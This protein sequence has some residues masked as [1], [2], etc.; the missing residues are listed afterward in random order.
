MNINITPLICISGGE[1]FISA[2]SLHIC[3]W[4]NEAAEC[5]LLCFPQRLFC[6]RS[7][8]VQTP[9]GGGLLHSPGASWQADSEIP[10]FLPPTRNHSLSS[11]L[12]TKV[13]S[14]SP[15]PSSRTNKE[16]RKRKGSMAIRLQINKPGKA[17]RAREEENRFQAGFRRPNS[18]NQTKTAAAYQQFQQHHSVRN[19]LGVQGRNA[20]RRQ[21]QKP[22][23]LK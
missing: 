10:L 5:P 20:R 2:L 18:E 12:S 17:A 19:V 8:G 1:F 23:A 22:E 3:T 14:S 13:R 6:L 11:P 15:R 21:D 16:T 4:Q 7:G 9:V